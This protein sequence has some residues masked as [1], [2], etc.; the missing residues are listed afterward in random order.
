MEVRVLSIMYL[1]FFTVFLKL[2]T[3]S[4]KFHLTMLVGDLTESNSTKIFQDGDQQ[5]QLG[6]NRHSID[7]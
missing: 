2:F 5:G 3:V 1:N 6:D 4:L 7:C